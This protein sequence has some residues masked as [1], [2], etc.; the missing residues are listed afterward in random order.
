LKAKKVLQRVTE[1][2]PVSVWQNYI[3]PPRQRR[4]EVTVE[5]KLYIYD[6]SS[7][8]DRIQAAQRFIG[9]KDVL[10]I[11]IT[12]GVANLQKVFEMLSGNNQ[13]FDRVVFQTHGSPGKIYFGNE[14]VD[15]LTL[16]SRFQNFDNLFPAYTRIYFDGCNVADGEDGTN[17][18]LAAGAVFLRR[19]GGEAFGWRNIGHAVGSQWIPF[20]RGHTIHLGGSS[21]LKTIRFF[22]G[23]T[24][25]WPASSLPG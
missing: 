25:N 7:N 13:K 24:P 4:H 21:N 5:N 18:L 14:H 2:G 11:G 19:A 10:A 16:K 1:I 17:F 8:I 15:A 23:G 22:Q 6:K 12:V 9:D 3:L 20:I